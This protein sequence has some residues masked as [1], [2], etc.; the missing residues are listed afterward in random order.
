MKSLLYLLSLVYIAYAATEYLPRGMK[1]KWYF[2]QPEVVTFEMWYPHKTHAGFD[3]VGIALQDVKDPR[4]NFKCDYYIA[5]LADGVFDDRYS[6]ANGSPPLDDVYGGTQDITS[7][8]YDLKDY[9]VITVTRK[10]ITG[11]V[12]DVPLFYG[13]PT[14][15]KWAIGNVDS[16]GVVQQHTMDNMG[17][18]YFV[19]SEEYEDRNHD[20]RGKYGPYTDYPPEDERLP[21]TENPEQEQWSIMVEA[22]YPAN[23]ESETGSYASDDNLD[24]TETSIEIQTTTELEEETTETSTSSTTTG[25]SAFYRN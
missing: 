5:L 25:L 18:E 17:F 13:R 24:K 19:L 15:L 10:L 7:E 11:D 14:V 6:E 22:M 23:V 21:E 12:Y 9:L 1:L 8:R 4:D 16:N 20:E 2:P 3:W